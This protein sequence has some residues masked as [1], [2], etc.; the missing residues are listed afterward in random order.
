MYQFEKHIVKLDTTVRQALLKLND[1]AS[2]AILF[3]VNEEG[4]LIG[5]L[6]DGDIR[7]GLIKGL[8]IDSNIEPFLQNKPKYVRQDRY[9]LSEIIQL[10]K[11]HFTILPVLNSKNVVVNV[12]NFRRLKSYLPLDTIIM[13]GGR[14]ARLKPLTDTVPKPM[15][16]IDNKP[17][18]EHNIDRLISYGMENFWISV[19]YLGNQIQNYFLNGQ[20]KN[21]SIEYLW[22]EKPL[23][24]IGAARLITNFKH[25]CLLATNS[26][27]LTNLDYEDFYLDFLEKQADVSVVSIPYKVD[28]PYA[29]LETSNGILHSFKEK[30]T[31]TYYSNGGIYLMKKAVIDYIPANS[32][33]NAT[34]LL[35][36]VIKNGGKVTTYPLAGYWID[37][38]NHQDYEKVQQDIHHIVF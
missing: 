15:L 27:I 28:I 19:R 33:F 24:T 31:Y 7:R 12:V 10:R 18:I 4:K 20:N 35:E 30:P 23:G 16:K 29:V 32:H 22:E 6:T 38:G 25:N 9:D 17:I 2:D 37:I 13:A 5:S 3:A 21:V 34:D 11:S 26:D 14:G 8:S 36:C 1:L